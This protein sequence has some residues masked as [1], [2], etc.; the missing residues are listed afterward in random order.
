MTRR[1]SASTHW[2][3]FTDGAIVG[4]HCGF[5]A[6]A[7]NDM[8]YGDSVVDHI[9]QVACAAAAEKIRREWVCPCVEE[10][11][12]NPARWHDCCK[13]SEWAAR[14]AERVGGAE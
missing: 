14:N 11:P 2:L 9:W 13:Y 7:E 6:D 12:N 4:C 1:I 3:L 8:T 10:H 5:R